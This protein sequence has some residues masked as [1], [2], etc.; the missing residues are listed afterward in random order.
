MR[1]FRDNRGLALVET[2]IILP[3]AS[4]AEVTA[5]VS[6]L[7]T[8]SNLDGTG[9]TVTI[10]PA[11]VEAQDAGTELRVTIEVPYGGVA[12]F[13]LP[14]IPLPATIRSSATMAKEGPYNS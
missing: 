13:N 7:M 10:T 3:D 5:R 11:S 12:L 8:A 1:R 2:A 9:Y 4:D 14:F 6:N